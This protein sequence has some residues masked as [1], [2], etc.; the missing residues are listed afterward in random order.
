MTPF[1]IFIENIQGSN[2]SLP[3]IE[4][5]IKKKFKALKKNG[6]D[7]MLWINMCYLNEKHVDPNK[8]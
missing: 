2:L 1:N 7:A 3:T 5:L 6:D 8:N 4:L